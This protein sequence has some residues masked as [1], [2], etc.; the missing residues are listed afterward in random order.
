[1]QLHKTKEG[2]LLIDQNKV[3]LLTESWDVIF[4]RSN[5]HQHLA[6]LSQI[7]EP[8]PFDRSQYLLSHVLAPIGNQEVWAAGVTYLRSRD[9]RMEESKSAGT[10]GS[11]EP[12]SILQS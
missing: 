5:L 8:L 12:E 4:N 1:M 2:A 9:A 11:S 6:E 10:V 7:S 3:F